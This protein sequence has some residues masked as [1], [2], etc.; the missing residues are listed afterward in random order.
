VSVTIK[1]VARLAGVS[2]ATVSAVVNGK[3]GV[4][5]KLRKNVLRAVANLNYHP[6]HVA[7]S[8]RTNKTKILGMIVPR[9]NSMFYS[10]V[11][12][13]AEDEAAR[14]GHSMLICY[15]GADPALE[16]RHLM[17]LLAR[18][19]DGVLLASAEAYFHPPW[20]VGHNVPIVFVDR[21]PGGRCGPAVSTSNSE[22]AQEATNHFISL[23]HRRIA[24]IASPLSISTGSERAEGFRRAMGAAGLPVQDEYFA[25][26]NGRLEG[27]YKSGKELLSLPLPPTAILAGNEEVTLGLIRAVAEMGIRCPEQVSLIGFDDLWTWPDGFSLA[28]MFVPKLTAVAQFGYVIGKAAVHTLLQN[29]QAI[30]KNQEKEEGIIRIPAELRIRDSTAPPPRS[31]N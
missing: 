6:D 18:R 30:E 4:S 25:C 3:T 1:D 20:R 10:Q 28:T 22:A 27:G 7:R 8:L 24:L 12:Q 31:D 17:T 14:E 13:G 29:I 16:Q 11:L 2:V 5:E 9:L 26:T 19:V 23:G 15:S 21:A